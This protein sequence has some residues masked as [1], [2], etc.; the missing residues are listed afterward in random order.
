MLF[1]H[2]HAGDGFQ[3][4]EMLLHDVIHDEECDLQIR[5]HHVHQMYA[6]QCVTKDLG[7]QVHPVPRASL[8]LDAC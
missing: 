5:D 7:S 6:M 2:P 1:A 8:H 4:Q 3:L